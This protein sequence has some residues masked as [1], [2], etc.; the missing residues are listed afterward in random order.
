MATVDA[1]QLDALL[2]SKLEERCTSLTDAFRKVDKSGNGF[3]AA[4]DFDETLRGFGVRVTR[5]SLAALMQRYDLNNDGLV[6]YAE[7][8]SRISGGPT[9]PELAKAAAIAAPS[10]A[11]RAEETLRRLMY[12]HWTTITEAFLKLDADRSGY[13]DKDEF[14]NIFRSAGIELTLDELS[15]L[16][17]RQT[18]ARKAYRLFQPSRRHSRLYSSRACVLPLFSTLHYSLTLP[19]HP[20][21]DELVKKYDVNDDG[22]LDV[23]ELARL[24]GGG[25]T[26]DGHGDRGMSPRK[27]ARR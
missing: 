1:A 25:S 12:S 22:R 7:F 19:A 11:D 8:C 26:Y 3:I 21:A 17:H 13:C 24:L 10:A 14:G 2:L 18:A 23:S 20:L 16:R 27:K 15:T 5:A 9:N 4:S 6:S